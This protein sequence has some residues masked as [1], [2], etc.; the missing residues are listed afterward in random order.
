MEIDVKLLIK[1]IEESIAKAGMSKTEFYKRSG[2]SSA[3]LSQWRTGTHK[4]ALKKVFSAAEALG[5]EPDYLL[6]RV[7]EP[8]P[9]TKSEN[10]KIVLYVPNL[11]PEERK[12]YMEW[13]EEETYKA[14]KRFVNLVENQKEKP[15]LPEEGELDSDTM[16]LLEAWNSSE[17]A[18]SFLLSAARMIK[19]RR[20][21]Q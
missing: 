10:G 9:T 12:E 20:E 2:I 16:E 4:P 18:K 17:E 3:S 1:R 15:T 5:V 6:G 21:E 14:A 19:S 8:N 13:N 7:D 11:T